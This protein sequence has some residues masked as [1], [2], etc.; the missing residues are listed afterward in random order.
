M[1]RLAEKAA[2]KNLILAGWFRFFPRTADV[3]CERGIGYQS[4]FAE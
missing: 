3:V 4:A 2:A 1:G